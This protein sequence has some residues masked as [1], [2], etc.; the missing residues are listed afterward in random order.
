MQAAKRSGDLLDQKRRARTAANAARLQAHK[1]LGERAGLMLAQHEL[2]VVRDEGLA[3]VSGFYPYQAEINV[4]PLL[5]RLVSEGWQTALPV[6]MAKGEPLTFRAWAPGEPTGRG[7]WDIHIPLETA[8]ELKPDVLLV[9]MLAFDRR[10]YRL[11]YGGGFY[12][13]TLAE[14]R[15]LKPV[16][17]IGVAYA[18]QEMPAVPI[19]SHDEPLDWILTERGVIEPKP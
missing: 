16:V 9:P 3:C 12:D 11:G 5:A 18:E 19:T 17:A 4:L 8:A 2:P 14:L 13:R 7:I 6:V 10:G 1:V 15:K